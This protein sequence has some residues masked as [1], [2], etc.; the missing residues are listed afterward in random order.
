MKTLKLAENLNLPADE[1]VTQKFGTAYVTELRE[2]IIANSVEDERG[3]WLWQKSK[4]NGYGQ[5]SVHRM[6]TYTHH[7]A[8]E[9]FIGPIPPGR[10]VCHRCDVS[11]CN[12]P[13]HL[14]LGTQAE[15][16]ADMRAKGRGSKPPVAQGETH[17]ATPLTDKQVVEIRRLA[18]EGKK[19]RDIAAQFGCCQAT[20]SSIVRGQY[21]R[22]A[23]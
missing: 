20:V 6:S 19:Q 13:A 17:H 9:L 8:Y 15:N 5:T 16:L 11:A 18:A 10:F 1:A 23:R 7:L 22:S 12:N 2:R 21:R 14:F 4:K 3:C